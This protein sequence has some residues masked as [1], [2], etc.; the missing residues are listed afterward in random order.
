MPKPQNLHLVMD[1][2]RDRDPH[3]NTGLS[4]QCPNEEQKEGEHE[5]GSQDHEE[6][7][8]SLRRWG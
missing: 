6:C 5:Q 3:W 2:D 4:S 7:A 8:P 1:G